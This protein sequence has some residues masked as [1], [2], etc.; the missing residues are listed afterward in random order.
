VKKPE[1]DDIVWEE[2]PRPRKTTRF[3]PRRLAMYRNP[4]KWMLW[5]ANGRSGSQA[6][7]LRNAG[8]EATSRT[9]LHPGSVR[10]Y[11]RW[12]E[13]KPVPEGVLDENV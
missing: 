5:Q 6:A 4:G 8:F 10:V 13:T 12:P 1:T 3:S 11:A 7:L 2:P 9:M